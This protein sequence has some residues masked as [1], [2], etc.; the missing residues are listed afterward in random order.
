MSKVADSPYIIHSQMESVMRKGEKKN[1]TRRSG[2]D[3]FSTTRLRKERV[4][5][6]S[7]ERTSNAK[8]R[9]SKKLY[10]PV[11]TI[12]ETKIFDENAKETEENN[13]QKPVKTTRRKATTSMERLMPFLKPKKEKSLQISQI[14]Y[15]GVDFPEEEIKENKAKAQFM[16]ELDLDTSEGEFILNTNS[17]QQMKFVDF[18]DLQIDEEESSIEYSR[19]S[20]YDEE[21]E[22]IDNEETKKYFNEEE[23]CK[24]NDD[25][26]KYFDE[27]ETDDDENILDELADSS[28]FEPEIS[29]ISKISTVEHKSD[30][31][32]FVS[33][34]N[35]LS[36]G[37]IG[38]ILNEIIMKN[39]PGRCENKDAVNDDLA[40]F[41]DLGIWL[42]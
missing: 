15:E 8:T 9:K 38:V 22:F 14:F 42:K 5:T 18:L 32:E 7:V 4:M 37:K 17:P 19:K 26:G 41:E 21:E 23:K 25:T 31:R 28:R 39:S 34:E 36:P 24:D 13:V 16:T 12:S 2:F 20:N 35:S 11:L 6:F 40:S 29:D 30:Y 33:D 27:E 10:D 1:D 3:P